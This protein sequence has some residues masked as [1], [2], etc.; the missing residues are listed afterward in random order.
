MSILPAHARGQSGERVVSVSVS[1][2]P[3][4]RPPAG[5]VQ[6]G[7]PLGHPTSPPNAPA[8]HGVVRGTQDYCPGHNGPSD[9]G[10]SGQMF[11]PRP[12]HHTRPESFHTPP[13]IPLPRRTMSPFAEAG[14]R[15]AEKVAP[16]HRLHQLTRRQLQ[17]IQAF[18]TT[19]SFPASSAGTGSQENSIQR[20]GLA[21]L[22]TPVVPRAYDLRRE[23]APRDE[24]AQSQAKD[25]CPG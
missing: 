8:Q 15:N 23:I 5:R 6:K 19:L 13:P 4:T 3:R 1:G 22:A 16:E 2:S 9:Q 12:P 10:L 24:A 14:V 25:G 20:R 21:K 17:T 7:Q 18:S 11:P